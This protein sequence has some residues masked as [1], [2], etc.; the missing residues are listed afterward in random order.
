MANLHVQA[1]QQAQ[2]LNPSDSQAAR[3][4]NKVEQHSQHIRRMVG[5]EEAIEQLKCKCAGPSAGPKPQPH[6]GKPQPG[7]P[8]PGK[9]IPHPGKPVLPNVIDGQPSKPAKP[10]YE[11]IRP[12]GPVIAPI[13]PLGGAVLAGHLVTEAARQ[14]IEKIQDF[15]SKCG[16]QTKCVSDN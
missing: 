15:Q 1:A 8:F 12:L 13:L 5:K 7:R 10:L 9:P 4:A 6:P 16:P 11:G 2:A 3:S 14:A